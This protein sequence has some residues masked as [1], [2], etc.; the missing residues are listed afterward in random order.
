[1]YPVSTMQCHQARILTCRNVRNFSRPVQAHT[2]RHYRDAIFTRIPTLSNVYRPFFALV[3][4]H[5]HR[6]Y[7]SDNRCLGSPLY[8]N[9]SFRRTFENNYRSRTPVQTGKLQPVKTVIPTQNI[10][11]LCRI[12]TYRY[13]CLSQPALEVHC[14]LWTTYKCNSHL[15]VNKC[16]IEK[17]HSFSSDHES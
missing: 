8:T 16:Y 2:H 7:G 11:W 13:F 12:V 6:W 5:S 15:L 14:L 4:S 9:S 1:M 17:K 10:V 3:R